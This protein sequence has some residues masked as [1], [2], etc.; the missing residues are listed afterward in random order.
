MTRRWRLLVFF[1][2]V[3]AL[4]AFF[5][6][7]S[8]ARI[9]DKYFETHRVFLDPAVYQE[10]LYKLWE[11]SHQHNRLELAGNELT[12]PAEGGGIPPLAFRSVPLLLLNPD[13]L[14]DRHAHLITS[15]FSLFIFVLLAL[16]TVYRRT[17]SFVYSMAVAALICS[18]PGM[19]EPVLGLGAFWLDLTAGFLGSAAMLCLINSKKGQYLGWLAGFA[20]LAGSSVLSRFVT[21]VYLFVQAGP[22][23]VFYLLHRWR[24][25]KSFVPVLAPVLVI[26]GVLCLLTGWYIWHQIPS[27]LFYYLNYGYGNTDPLTS[28]Q[29][30]F[31]TALS[32]VGQNFALVCSAIFLFQMIFGARVRWRGAAEL[33]WPAVAV[34]LFLGLSGEIGTSPQAMQYSCPLLLCALLCPIDWRERPEFGYSRSMRFFFTAIAPLILLVV[35]VTS[36]NQSLH[37]WLWRPPRPSAEEKDRKALIDRLTDEIMQHFPDKVVGAYFDQFDEYA[38]VTAFEKYGRPPRLLPGRAFDIRAEYLNADFPNKSPKELAD[39][40]CREAIE[41]CDIVLVFNDPAAAFKPAPFDYGSC[42]NPYSEEI[43]SRLAKLVQTDRNWKLLFVAPS[44]YLPGGVAGYANL[45]R[46]PDAPAAMK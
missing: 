9:E 29:L 30:A 33:L 12:N 8:V 27:Q 18:T 11:A 22:L 45:T 10:H 24:A 31:V 13:L 19:Y 20:L 4:F 5:V 21:G 44:K 41:K 37:G 40:A 2:T 3:S 25:T 7:H 36:L 42:L 28:C 16:Y 1:S 43:A 32:F 35:A 14:K 38:F 46:F 15:G 17:G 34:G 26:G 39:M 6:V 23:L